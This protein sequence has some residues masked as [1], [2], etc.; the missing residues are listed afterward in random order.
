[1]S[2]GGKRGL[3][4]F[5]IIGASV[6]VMVP[7][8]NALIR[9]SI[10]TWLG[11]AVLILVALGLFLLRRKLRTL[12][13][14]PLCWAPFVTGIYFRDHG[15]SDTPGFIVSIAFFVLLFVGGLLVETFW[16]PYADDLADQEWLS[17]FKE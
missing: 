10:L 5:A 8:T 9:S 12:F 15:G 17:Q 3:L 14:V 6:V 2:P 16:S 7:I 1:M 11:V 13:L 4:R